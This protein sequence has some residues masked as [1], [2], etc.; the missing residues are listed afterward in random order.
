MCEI[1]IYM[2]GKDK[3]NWRACDSVSPDLWSVE[4]LWNRGVFNLGSRNT[5]HN[6]KINSLLTLHWQWVDRWSDELTIVHRKRERVVFT[7]FK[8]KCKYIKY[9]FEKTLVASHCRRAMSSPSLFYVTVHNEH[10]NLL[11]KY[12]S[13]S[14]L[15]LS[16]IGFQTRV[17]VHFKLMIYHN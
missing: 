15:K 1:S 3:F 9:S 12:F 8:K 14:I 11:L 4:T 2:V 16:G 7:F 13:L 17:A 10:F 5:W 6:M